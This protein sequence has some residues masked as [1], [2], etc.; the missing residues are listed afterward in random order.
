MNNED[1]ER[2]A[3]AVEGGD[4]RGAVR[5]ER[6]PDVPHAVDTEGEPLRMRREPPVDE[7]DTDSERGPREPQ[8]E[9]PKEQAPERAAPE[10]DED[11]RHDQDQHQDGKYDPAAQTVRDQTQGDAEQGAQDHRRRDNDTDLEAG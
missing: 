3:P 1:P 6:R 2:P 9:P 4:G 7:R 11:H 10:P 8:E 5:R